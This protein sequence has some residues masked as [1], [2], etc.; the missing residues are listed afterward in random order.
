MPEGLME[1]ICRYI[2][3]DN[4]KGRLDLDK[5]FKVSFLAQ[6]EYNKNY[7]LEDSKNKYVFRVNTG[8]Q[9][10]I[11]N[12]IEYEYKALKRLEESKYT[13]KVHFVDGS[14]TH[15]D[16]GVLIMDYLEGKPLNDRKDLKKAA[17]IFSGI[18][19]LEIKRKDFDY[20]IT[21]NYIFSDRLKEADN[22]LKKFWDNPSADKKTKI[23][24]EKYLSWCRDNSFM[25]KYF[26]E[27]SWKAINNTEVNSHNFI[28]GSERSYLI[29]WEKPVI[30]DP[31]QDI[32]QFL[33][34]TTTLWKSNTLLSKD[35]IEEFYSVYEKKFQNKNIRERVRMYTPY[36]YLR[37]LSWC[38]Y[39]YIEYQDPNKTIRNPDTYKKVCEYLDVDFMRKLLKE[40]MG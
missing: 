18:H 9:I 10:G 7:I 16:Y 25:E 23:F 14:K 4:L 5:D 33:A 11:S 31:C 1:K 3:E 19:S 15:L 8:S 32:T 34:P 36:L 24:F 2:K 27:D 30:S 12:Q 22:L 28:I 13:P 35:E 38:A 26:I 40:W 20:L 37:A 17:E 6:G 29:D 39:A 21:E